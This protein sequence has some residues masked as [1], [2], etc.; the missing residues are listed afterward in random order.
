MG[1]P[2]DEP[3]PPFPLK[4]PVPLSELVPQSSADA[5]RKDRDDGDE[6]E[7][8]PASVS[9][10][11]AKRPKKSATDDAVSTNTAAPPLNAQ[12]VASFIPFLSPEDLS[13]PKLPTTEQMEEVLL[14][15]RKRALLEEYFGDGPPSAVTAA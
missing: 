10:T 2:T 5:K 15:L 1:L 9:D 12:L 13:P 14:G 4:E 6:I 7:V 11:T 8:E 3:I